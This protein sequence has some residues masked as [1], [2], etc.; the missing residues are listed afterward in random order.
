MKIKTT[1]LAALLLPSIAFAQYL[2]PSTGQR[3]DAYGRPLPSVEEM[4]REGQMAG[5][6]VTYQCEVNDYRFNRQGERLVRYHFDKWG[7]GVLDT[8]VTMADAQRLDADP[9][10]RA[11]Y[12]KSHGYDKYKVRDSA[13]PASHEGPASATD[14]DLPPDLQTPRGKRFLSHGMAASYKEGRGLIMLSD[15]RCEGQPG[16][17]ARLDPDEGDVQ[18]GCSQS[19][20]PNRPFTVTWDDGSHGAYKP[21]EFVPTDIGLKYLAKTNNRQ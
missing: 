19:F 5:G 2:N 7:Y 9:V 17:V 8:A 4:C 21:K 18:Y 1:L 3:F 11:K 14:A 15:I 20:L 12:I 10:F 16:Y 13:G 6:P